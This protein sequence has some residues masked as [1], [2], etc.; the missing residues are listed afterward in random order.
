MYKITFNIITLII[1]KYSYKEIYTCKYLN[2][3]IY[4]YLHNCFVNSNKLIFMCTIILI[5]QCVYLY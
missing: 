3:I 5:N 4:V 2:Y 1:C